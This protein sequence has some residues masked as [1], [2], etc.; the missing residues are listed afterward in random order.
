M[1]LSCS[2]HPGAAELS[3]W[4]LARGLDGTAREELLIG[5]CDKLLEIGLPLYRLHVTQRALHPRF[6]GIGFDWL[7]GDRGVSQ[8]RYAHSDISRQD[9]LQSPLFQIAS[10]DRMEVRERLNAPGHVS[11]FPFLNDLRTRGATDYFAT[12]LLYEKPPEPTKLDPSNAPEGMLSSWTSDHPDGFSEAD[13]DLIRATLPQ[14][15]LAM[16]SMSN[17][18]IAY[19]LLGTYLGRDAGKRVLSGE[20]Q[21]GSFQRIDAVICYF[22]LSGFTSLAERIPGPD[23]IAMLNAYFGVVVDAIHARGGHVLKFMGDGVL[24]M[25]DLPEDGVATRAALDTVADLIKQIKALNRDRVAQDLPV[26]GFTIALHAGEIFYGNIGAETRL[27]FTVI[28]PAVN[29]TARL[30]DMH[31]TLGQNVILSEPIRNAA[32]GG[33][34]DLVSLGRYM[35]RGV[36]QPQELFTLYTAGT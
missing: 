32:L 17:R 21:R 15:G 27:D 24:A 20:I 14:L 25:F 11:A 36:S 5:Y 3:D 13:I 7:R 18:R 1:P 31:R 6:G 34:H 12:G 28:G 33:P 10:S 22:D 29:L 26:T 35:L 2:S 16:K 4:L 8:Q 23:L 9:W 19:D 30:A